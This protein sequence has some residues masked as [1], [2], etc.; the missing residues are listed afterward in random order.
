MIALAW[1]L[2][3]NK[4]P[5]RRSV[6]TGHLLL[7]IGKELLNEI[8]IEISRCEDTKWGRDVKYLCHPIINYIC[9][10][11]VPAKMDI[12]IIWVMKKSLIAMK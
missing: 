4:E 6:W 1:I 8:E 11:I 10:F 5:M 12:K 9:N 7:F 2:H 3:K